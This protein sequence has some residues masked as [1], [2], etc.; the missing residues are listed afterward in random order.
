MHVRPAAAVVALQ[1]LL[2]L[3]VCGQ[4]LAGRVTTVHDGDTVTVL[5]ARGPVRVRLLGIDC[6]EQGQ[7]FSARARRYTSDMTLGR[8]VTVKANGRDQYDRLLGRVF[9][10]G[11]DLNRLLVQEGLAWQY[12]RNGGDPALADA[13][14]AA[15]AA[16]RGLWSATNPVPPWQWRRDHSESNRRSRL[17]R[18]GPADD[19]RGPLRGNTRSRLYHRPGCANY[20][21]RRCTEVFLSEASAREAGFRPAADCHR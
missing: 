15:R 19:G 20:Q 8:E 12:E 11:R 13:Q 6:P 14:R 3:P 18:A 10:G 21:C 9:V 7:P 2:A 1:V 4:T 16:R 5:S 17:P